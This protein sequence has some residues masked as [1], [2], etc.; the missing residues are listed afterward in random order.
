MGLGGLASICQQLVAHG[1]NAG[2]PVAI[3]SKGTTPEQQVLKGTLET[4]TGLAARTQ[5]QTPTLIIVGEVVD[6]NRS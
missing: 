1:R 5:V 2:T 4:I 3:I 6:F